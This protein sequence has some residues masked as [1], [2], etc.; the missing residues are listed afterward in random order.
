[1]AYQ[2][3]ETGIQALRHRDHQAQVRPTNPGSS[4]AGSGWRWLFGVGGIPAVRDRQPSRR[5]VHGSESESGG[6]VSAHFVWS[7]K[8][9]KLKDGIKIHALAV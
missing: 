7:W 9:A 3:C 1:M 2:P 4:G 8:L 5:S 6:A